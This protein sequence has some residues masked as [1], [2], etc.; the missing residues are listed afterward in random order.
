MVLNNDAV[1][2]NLPVFFDMKSGKVYPL[3]VWFHQRS[4]SFVAMIE[5]E[6]SP[7]LVEFL[8]GSPVWQSGT[9][10]RDGFGAESRWSLAYGAFPNHQ[11]TGPLHIAR[12][13]FAVAEKPLTVTHNGTVPLLFLLFEGYSER[14]AFGRTRFQGPTVRDRRRQWSGSGLLE[15][16]RS[17]QGT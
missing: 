17:S 5:G 12:E 15:S 7:M 4:W 3:R 14:A 16:R 10:E 2:I 11:Q 9:H 13:I 6:M 8:I 1:M